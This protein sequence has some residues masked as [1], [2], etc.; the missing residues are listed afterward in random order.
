MNC[1]FPS[2]LSTLLFIHP[3][4]AAQTQTQRSLTG[5]IITAKNEVVAGATITVRSTTSELTAMS[6]SEGNFQLT[7]PAEVLIGRSD[8]SFSKEGLG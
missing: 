8:F 2:V 7:V 6:D 5:V 1:L 4:I 3:L